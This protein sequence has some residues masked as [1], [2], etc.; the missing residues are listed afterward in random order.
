MNLRSVL[1]RNTVGIISK[2]VFNL[3][4][5]CLAVGEYTRI[6]P[7]KGIVE[8]ITSQ[9]IEYHLLGS[10]IFAT[11]VHRTKTVIERKR[12]RLF[13]VTKKIIHLSKANVENI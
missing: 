4:L 3:E 5:T 6:V 12:F 1:K 13:P 7:L 8:N 2:K 11:G 9:T 10:E